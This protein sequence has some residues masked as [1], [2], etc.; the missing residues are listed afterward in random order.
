MGEGTLVPDLTC[1]CVCRSHRTARHTLT[2]KLARGVGSNEQTTSMRINNR[3]RATAREQLRKPPATNKQRTSFF[4][5]GARGRVAPEIGG[6]TGASSPR[7]WVG[8]MERL[9]SD[10]A[11]WGV[12]FT[13]VLYAFGQVI[14]TFRLIVTYLEQC[15]EMS[16]H[17][18]PHQ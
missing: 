15:V 6:G 2:A 11:G 3:Y 17:R 7:N 18:R 5:A 10:R 4:V 1:V 14:G 12:S 13:I 8:A 16:H 9:W